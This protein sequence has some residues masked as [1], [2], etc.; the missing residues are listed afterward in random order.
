MNDQE[1]DSRRVTRS[2]AHTDDSTN[3]WLGLNLFGANARRVRSRSPSV[4]SN[5]SSVPPPEVLL[6]PTPASDMADGTDLPAALAGLSFASR[7]PELPAFDRKNVEIWVRRVENAFIRSNV[8]SARDKFAYIEAKFGVDS[9]SNINRFLY[10]AATDANWES[11]VSYLKDRY[12]K[13]TRDKCAAVLDPVHRNGR[14]PSDMFSYILERMDN[15]TL[16]E[17]VKEKVL[18]ELPNEIRL[19]IANA[20]KDLTPEETMKVADGYFTRDGHLL[21]KGNPSIN[22]VSNA[23]NQPPGQED[24]AD[25]NAVRNG[26]RPKRQP[27]RSGTRDARSKSRPR[28]GS[29]Y[30]HK[31]P[32][33]CYYHDR[34]AQKARNCNPGCKWDKNPNAQ[35]PRRA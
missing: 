17:I 11:F 1:R 23:A 20:V 21:Y 3:G 31:N 26:A 10:G 18:R 2:Q 8:T 27:E 22:A 12:G 16:H 15:V 34:Y 33:F 6:P 7:K 9:D 19:T 14:L 4:V 30:V 28:N 24:D 25:I 32:E 35:G 5:A 13:S 29:D